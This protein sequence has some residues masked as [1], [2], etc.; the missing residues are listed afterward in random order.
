MII[1]HIFTIWTIFLPGIPLF[2]QYSQNKL[3]FSIS[4]LL[5]SQTRKVLIWGYFKWFF[6]TRRSS[7]TVNK[8]FGILWVIAIIFISDNLLILLMTDFLNCF[9]FLFTYKMKAYTKFIWYFLKHYS[10]FLSHLICPTLF[11]FLKMAKIK[12]ELN[13][14]TIMKL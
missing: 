14:F 1:I 9:G 10:I 13:I 8:W 6:W 7:S 5:F 2:C 3:S 11:I 12:Y 4:Y